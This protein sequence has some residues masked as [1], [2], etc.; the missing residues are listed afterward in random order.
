MI[1]IID[2]HNYRQNF[3]GTSGNHEIWANHIRSTAN[4]LLPDASSS[5]L[6]VYYMMGETYSFNAGQP[7]RRFIA[8][9]NAAHLDANIKEEGSLYLP[10]R[11]NTLHIMDE[12]GFVQ[13]EFD[14]NLWELWILFDVFKATNDTQFAVFDNILKELNRLYFYPLT[15]ETSWVH[16]SD[17]TKLTA[18][19]IDQLK[20][21]QES[22]LAEEKG[23]LDSMKDKVT[24]YQQEIKNLLDNI[25]RTGRQI[26]QEEQQVG[27]VGDK[28]LKDLDLIVQ[29]EKVKDLHIKDN[30]F[31][32]YT[33]PLYMYTEKGERFYLGNMRIELEPNRSDVRFFGDNPRQGYWTSHDPHPHVDGDGGHACL[34]SAAPLIAELSH[35]MQLYPLVLTAIDF[36]E[37]ANIQDPAG[38]KVY[39]WDRVD[40][41]GHIME[42]G[43]EEEEE[44][45]TYDFY[46][47][48]CGDG[49][50]DGNECL[51]Y[52][53]VE[54]D[55]AVR[56]HIVCQH[57]R[58]NYY[59]YDENVDEY[60]RD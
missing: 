6:E 7:N 41:E 19:L 42:P 22:Y 8:F 26:V 49:I 16:T 44:P 17:K 40:E 24:R 55:E 43:G 20:T 31:I 54:D 37:Q 50:D 52:E 33:N 4:Q 15:L 5:R 46:C 35:Q 29:H 36:L 13:A 2:V 12:N 18:A 21:Q 11:P 10:H 60:I 14:K 23:R 30:K 3:G 28:L 45:E 9:G 1:Q 51:V 25:A 39:H 58:E 47:Y 57:C 53:A 38:A 56:D 34:G 32:V 48:E 59:H 27:A